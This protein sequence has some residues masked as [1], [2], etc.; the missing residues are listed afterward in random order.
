MLRIFSSWGN[1]RFQSQGA[2]GFRLRFREVSRRPLFHFQFHW[3][4]GLLLR[5]SGNKHRIT[6]NDAPSEAPRRSEFQRTRHPGP[7]EGKR[8][9]FRIQHIIQCRKAACRPGA[10]WG[11]QSKAHMLLSSTGFPG[12]GNGNRN[13]RRHDA[14]R[15]VANPFPLRMGNLGGVATLGGGPERRTRASLPA[16]QIPRTTPQAWYSMTLEPKQASVLIE[17]G[18]SA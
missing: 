6:T 10:L 3:E 18:Y 9:A 2:L 12:V 1:Q 7:S 14:A 16:S 5:N 17:A 13:M 11:P 4:L 8:H 15:T